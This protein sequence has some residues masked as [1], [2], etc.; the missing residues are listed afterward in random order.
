MAQIREGSIV[1]VTI[2]EASGV[3]SQDSTYGSVTVDD[4][5]RDGITFDQSGTI[6]LFPWSSV[7]R[8]ILVTH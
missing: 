3:G 2:K 8:I 7:R 1:N 5:T 4:I 6:Y